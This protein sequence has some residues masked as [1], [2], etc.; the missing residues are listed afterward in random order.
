M[1]QATARQ[2]GGYAVIVDPALPQGKREADTLTCGHC[3][4]IVHLGLSDPEGGGCYQCQTPLCKACVD[5]GVCLPFEAWLDAQ[6]GRPLRGRWAETFTDWRARR[7][8]Q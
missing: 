4:R 5:A 6:E 7:L 1:Y 3:N 2:P 8:G